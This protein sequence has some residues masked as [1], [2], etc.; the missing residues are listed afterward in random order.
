MH[1]RF[2]AVKEM[3]LDLLGRDGPPRAAFDA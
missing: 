2:A 1:A 3:Q